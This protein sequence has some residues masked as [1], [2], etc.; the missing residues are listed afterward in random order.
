MKNEN[1]YFLN[2]GNL[3][4]QSDETIRVFSRLNSLKENF[5]KWPKRPSELIKENLGEEFFDTL[6]H[7]SLIQQSDVLLDYYLYF[8]PYQKV[9]Q[10]TDNKALQALA[11]QYT[12]SFIQHVRS[13]Q[14]NKVSLFNFLESRV[15]PSQIESAAELSDGNLRVNYKD[16]INRFSKILN[17][18]VRASN[19]TLNNDIKEAELGTIQETKISESLEF[20]DESKSTTKVA[21]ETEV[22]IE[23]IYKQ[24][25]YS[26]E[27][28]DL[29]E[30]QAVIKRAQSVATKSGARNRQKKQPSFNGAKIVTYALG[31]T[32][33]FATIFVNVIV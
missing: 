30:E 9:I 14:L 2:L 12:E 26:N 8:F 29:I 20:T 5:E 13:L 16:S 19:I 3:I 1:I 10:E 6:L 24:D 22:E 31:G 7:S 33:G 25:E 28:Y 4:K 11:I 15:N 32:L 18:D 21:I 27:Y 17:S 23:A